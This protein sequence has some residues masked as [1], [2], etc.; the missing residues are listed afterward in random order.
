M[1]GRLTSRQ[2]ESNRSLHGTVLIQAAMRFSAVAI[3]HLTYPNL[4]V[5]DVAPPVM[6]GPWAFWSNRCHTD[7][8]HELTTAKSRAR[9]RIRKVTERR[10]NVPGP[11]GNSVEG[12]VVGIIE[13][14]ERFS[15]IRL[16]DGTTLRMKPNIQ[17]VV[18]LT[19]MWDEEGNPVY[20]V[21][22]N[23]IISIH[24]APSDLR[25]RQK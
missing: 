24:E 21:S 17:R 5:G 19:D 22:H 9:R 20:W 14:R 6:Y 10:V 16:E 23:A 15:E 1:I 12:V 18:R 3:P 11:D 4:L 8:V 13:S 7:A 2:L 25:R